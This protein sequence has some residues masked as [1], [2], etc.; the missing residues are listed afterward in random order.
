MFSV[1]HIVITDGG[2]AFKGCFHE[3]I[4]TGYGIRHLVSAPYHPESNAFNERSHA[5][6]RAM[7]AALRSE[8]D[9][10]LPAAIQMATAAYNATPHSSMIV[11]PYEAL[12]GRMPLYPHFQECTALPTEVQRK[13]VQQAAMRDRLQ[14]VALQQA[15]LTPP[16]NLQPGDIVVARNVQGNSATA[17]MMLTDHAD[18]SWGLPNWSL[19]MKVLSVTPTQATLERYGF[20]KGTVTRHRNHLKKFVLPEEDH[21]KRLLRQYFHYT[22]ANEMQASSNHTHKRP[23][24]N[25]ASDPLSSTEELLPA[26]IRDPPLDKP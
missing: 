17:P 15:T 25:T 10:S 4:A 6:L 13:V 20:A 23:R 19:P 2:T 5:T 22:M 18:S 12:F 11:S 7:T 8:Y 14:V 1:S 21:F 3:A 16:T 24:S 9:I 26:F